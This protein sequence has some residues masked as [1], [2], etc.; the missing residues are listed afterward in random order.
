MFATAIGLG[1]AM[2]SFL[3]AGVTF[4]GEGT[5]YDKAD[6]IAKTRC[7]AAQVKEGHNVLKYAPPIIGTATYFFIIFNILP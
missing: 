5:R 1:Q 2:P 6:A 4:P 3:G 7:W